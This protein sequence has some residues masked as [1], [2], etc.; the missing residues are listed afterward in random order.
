MRSASGLDRRVCSTGVVTDGREC[1]AVNH[2]TDCVQARHDTD[3]V[4]L[5]P[6]VPHRAI[7]DRPTRESV[8]ERVGRRETLSRGTRDRVCPAAL[9]VPDIFGITRVRRLAGAGLNRAH[10]CPS[11]ADHGSRRRCAGAAGFARTG[12]RAMRAVGSARRRPLRAV[13]SA[14]RRVRRAVGA[15]RFA[16]GEY[17]AARDPGGVPGRPSTR[18]PAAA[19]AR[20]GA[21]LGSRVPSASHQQRPLLRPFLPWAST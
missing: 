2:A 13:D 21:P 5:E 3:S 7:R 20:R 16:Y 18:F 14:R 8:H 9:A 12:I 15:T 19:R 11:N 17:C 4:D 6:R 1:R 10:R